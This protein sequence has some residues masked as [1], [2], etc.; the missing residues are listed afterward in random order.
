M[1]N[2]FYLGVSNVPSF[3]TSDEDVCMGRIE[4]HSEFMTVFKPD[5]STSGLFRVEIFRS[6]MSAKILFYDHEINE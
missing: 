5:D 6:W 2:Q 1:L 4:L 3:T